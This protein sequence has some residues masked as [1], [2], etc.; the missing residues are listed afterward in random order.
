M[1]KKNYAMKMKLLFI[2]L[3]LLSI[4]D[5]KVTKAQGIN[6]IKGAEINSE[7]KMVKVIE[8]INGKLF[9]VLKYSKKYYL[10]SYHKNL[11]VANFSELT[12]RYNGKKLEY[13]DVVEIKSRLFYLC[14]YNNKK[15]KKKFLLYQEIN[16]NTLAAINELTVLGEIPYKKRRHD[17]GFKIT[18]SH[19]KNKVLVYYSMPYEKEGQQKIT[20]NV[21]D[22]NLNKLWQ[23]NI[24]LPYTDKLFTIHDLE[25]DNEGNVYIIGRKWTGEHGNSKRAKITFSFVVLGYKNEGKEEREYKLVF[26]DKYITQARLAID[27]D[28][29]LICAGFYSN[30]DRYHGYVGYHSQSNPFYG[31]SHKDG[32]FGIGGAFFLKINHIDGNVMISNSK[33]FSYSFLYKGSNEQAEKKEEKQNNEE[34]KP[35]KTNRLP[36]YHLNEIVI[37]SDGGILLIAEH[38]YVIEYVKTDADGMKHKSHE[39]NANNIIVLNFNPDGNVK[40]MHMVTKRQS[41]YSYK[42]ISYVNAVYKDNLLFIY[43]DNI[44]NANSCK[45]LDNKGHAKFHSNTTPKRSNLVSYQINS[46]NEFEYS[47]LFNAKTEKFMVIP[48]LSKQLKYSNDVILVSIWDKK[49]RLYRIEFEDK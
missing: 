17:G 23:K 43:N 14:I 28:L 10:R 13:K 25:V 38:T 36:R 19:N 1:S 48:T 29:N 45:D 49:L 31:T 15:E 37:R 46:N 6:I 11:E 9:T 3:L 20:I 16:P 26:K 4:V 42:Y 32:Y 44:K 41:S 2:L 7:M 33:E 22:S 18:Y 39:Y 47:I 27:N 40:W 5:N 8:E 30:S 12:M 24:T 34:E 21:L 35:S